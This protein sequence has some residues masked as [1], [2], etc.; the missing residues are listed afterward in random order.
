MV[1]VAAIGVLMAV[2]DLRSWRNCG[3]AVRRRSMEGHS[4]GE[5]QEQQGGTKDTETTHSPYVGLPTWQGQADRL[6]PQATALALAFAL[7]LALGKA[8]A[9]SLALS[10]SRRQLGHL[11][12]IFLLLGGN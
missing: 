2:R 7:G 10:Q 8:D 4:K 5:C 6:H 9:G 12:Q 11:V 1:L 3:S